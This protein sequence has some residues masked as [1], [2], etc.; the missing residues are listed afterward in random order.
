MLRLLNHVP[1]GLFILATLS[2]CIIPDTD[3]QVV[4]ADPCGEEWVAQTTGAYGY[5]GLGQKK[6]IINPADEW[7]TKRYCVTPEQGLEL[8][9]S[10]TD[11]A[12]DYI[13]DIAALCQ[14]RAIELEIG[15]NDGTCAST[16]QLTYTGECSP[17]DGCGETNGDDEV[18]TTESTTTTGSGVAEFESLDL[19]AEVNF[20]NGEYMVSRNLIEAAMADL[21]GISNDGTL[22]TL[23]EDSLGSPTGFRMSG[24]TSVNLGGVLG[25]QNGDVITSVSGHSVTTYSDLSDVMTILVSADSTTL[26]LKRGSMTVTLYY[27]RDL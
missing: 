10:T 2:S 6:D 20:E 18:G 27:A 7:I 13:A 25:L 1:T 19:S 23:A 21:V 17:N 9:D 24:I 4:I 26:T 12:T 11:L 5:N 15:D 14:I 8:S 3:I 22:A 16:A